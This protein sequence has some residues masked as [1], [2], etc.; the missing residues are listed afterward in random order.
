MQTEDIAAALAKARAAV[1]GAGGYTPQPAGGAADAPG[2]AGPAEAS[3]TAAEG[4]REP[5]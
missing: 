5:R 2:V 4:D 1:E 3:D